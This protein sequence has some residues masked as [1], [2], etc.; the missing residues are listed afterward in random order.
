MDINGFLS[1]VPLSYYKMKDIDLL[2]LS[3]KHIT[4]SNIMWCIFT[5]SA[6]YKN[7]ERGCTTMG[8]FPLIISEPLLSEVA[9]PL[10]DSIENNPKYLLQSYLPP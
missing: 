4:N 9:S 5:D 3:P 2:T 6:R 8:T 7:R 10:I 1:W